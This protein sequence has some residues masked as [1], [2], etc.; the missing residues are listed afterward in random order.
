MLFISD[1]GVSK[2]LKRKYLMHFEVSTQNWHVL[3]VPSFYCQS[4]KSTGHGSNWPTMNHER[5]RRKEEL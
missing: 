5:E 2:K 3:T 4:P 1:G